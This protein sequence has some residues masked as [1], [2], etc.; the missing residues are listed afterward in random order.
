MS[1]IAVNMIS[2]HRIVYDV[3][4]L[5]TIAGL[6]GLRDAVGNRITLEYDKGVYYRISLPDIASSSLVLKSITALKHVLPKDV[7]MQVILY[8]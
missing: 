4:N 8:E 1:I 7:V 6:L 3:S 5:F 2:S